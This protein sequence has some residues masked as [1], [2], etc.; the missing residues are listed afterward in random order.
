MEPS[1]LPR[2]ARR[3]KSGE[4]TLFSAP[5]ASCRPWYPDE[6]LDETQKT[7]REVAVKPEAPFLGIPELRQAIAARFERLYDYSV[8]WENEIIVTSGSMQAE[9]YLMS[10]LLNPGDEVIVPVP[11]FFFDI[12]V[13]LA[14]GKPVLA[15]LNP[16]KNY[17]HDKKDF[18]KL[19]TKK[20][21]L[22]TLCNPHNPTG[23]GPDRRRAFRDGR[24]RPEE[25][26]LHH[27]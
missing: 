14:R 22:I 24:A 3:W 21:K 12:P 9:Y 18:E 17:F 16:K 2:K 1:S 5:K 4:P 11:S 20:T 19:V 13:K 27:A 15:K 6:V 23:Q 26:S 25:R 7:M 10:A 8:N